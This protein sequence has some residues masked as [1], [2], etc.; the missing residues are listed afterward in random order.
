[1]ETKDQTT[2]TITATAD[3]RGNDAAS[4]VDPKH[5]T[6]DQLEDF[7]IDVFM[8]THHPTPLSGEWA[9][10]S[11][12]ELFDGLL[13]DEQDSPTDDDLDAYEQAFCDAFY[14]RVEADVAAALNADRLA[15]VREL[16]VYQLA[17]MAYCC[18]PDADDSPGADFL[19][20]VRDAVHE[21][22]EHDYWSPHPSDDIVDLADLCVPVYTYNLM[23]TMVELGAYDEDVS[24]Y[25]P[26]DIESAARAALYVIAE[27]LM[28]EIATDILGVEF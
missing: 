1:M 28:I 23:T 8:D 7:D 21:H 22:H 13:P 14:A 16:N 12:A 15:R 20:I 10:E 4:W 24:E 11:I 2:T 5:W 6:T 18:S 3:E 25:S 9:G 17:R 26:T 27:R 19:N